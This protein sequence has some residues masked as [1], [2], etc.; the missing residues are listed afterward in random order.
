[1]RKPLGRAHWERQIAMRKKRDRAQIED[2][3]VNGIEDAVFDGTM[4]REQA[5]YWYGFIGVNCGLGGL[6]PRRGAGNL[7][8]PAYMAQLKRVIRGRLASP[9]YEAPAPIP[10]P[11]PGEVVE[12]KPIKMEGTTKEKLSQFFS[13][14]TRKEAA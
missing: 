8:H 13:N 10:G 9:V 5:R 12:F 3:I 2:A 11:K 6:L 4:T 14:S 7:L 1:L